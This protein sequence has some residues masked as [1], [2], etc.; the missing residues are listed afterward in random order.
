MRLLK[1]DIEKTKFFA[2]KTFTSFKICGTIERENT[3][4]LYRGVDFD[5]TT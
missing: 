1:N 5:E 4:T 3:N 2:V